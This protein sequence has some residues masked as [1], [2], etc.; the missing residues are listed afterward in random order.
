ME[1]Y[2][3]IKQIGTRAMNYDSGVS[4]QRAWEK[5]IEKEERS[6]KERP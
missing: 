6:T 5:I 3:D 1:R 4:M 2:W